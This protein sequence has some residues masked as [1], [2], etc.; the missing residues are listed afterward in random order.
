MSDEPLI[1]NPWKRWA[2]VL[3]V[4]TLLALFFV[5]QSMTAGIVYGEEMDL[6][7]MV[8]SELTYWYVWALMSPI[9][10]YLARRYRMGQPTRAASVSP[11]SEARPLTLGRGL[12]I[13][14]LFGL[15]MSAA[16]A[17]FTF[18]GVNAIGEPMRPDGPVTF[19]FYMRAGFPVELFTGFYKYWLIVLIYWA[20][21][22]SR[23]LRQR[24]VQA[25][26]LQT[27]L[28][29][30]QLQALKMQLHPHFLFNT[31]HSV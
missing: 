19:G 3:G 4:W 7:R 24:E 22:Y 10:L 5:M 25:A 21:D 30:A 16:H 13:H 31:L 6:R 23:K 28:A 8:G 15:L 11:V 12:A 17:V 14:S 1:G 18:L 26:Q 2:V 29:Q 9:V 20:L 27:Q